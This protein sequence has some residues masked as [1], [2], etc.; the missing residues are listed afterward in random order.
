MSNHVKPACEEFV[1]QLLAYETAHKSGD[2]RSAVFHVCEKLRQSLGKLL[3]VGG[4]RALLSRALALAGAQVPW[5]RAVH[6][7]ADG[8][9]EGMDALE[10]KLEPGEITQGHVAILAQVF[11]LLVTFIGPSLTL[12]LIQD[13]WPKAKFERLDF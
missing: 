11:A 1:G 8:S 13:A 4:F 12:E 7:K 9:L 2:S 10:A 6:I 5:L 3:G